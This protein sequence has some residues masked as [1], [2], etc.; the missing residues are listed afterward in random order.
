VNCERYLFRLSDVNVYCTN[1]AVCRSLVS[2]RCYCW[3]CAEMFTSGRVE[4]ELLK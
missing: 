1:T 3:E 4:M 2:G